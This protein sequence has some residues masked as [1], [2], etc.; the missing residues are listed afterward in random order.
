MRLREEL[1][2]LCGDS[3]LWRED[4]GAGFGRVVDRLKADATRGMTYAEIGFENIEQAKAVCVK[5]EAIGLPCNVMI[6]WFT[7]PV[8]IAEWSTSTPAFRALGSRTFLVSVTWE[9]TDPK[10]REAAA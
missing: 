10:P 3:N 5:L 6:E 7:N 9:I 4:F 1:A 8:L 2:K